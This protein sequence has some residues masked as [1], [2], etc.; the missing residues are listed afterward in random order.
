MQNPNGEIRELH[1]LV[2]RRQVTEDFV[3]SAAFASHPED[4]TFLERATLIGGRTVYRLRVRPP[5]GEPYVIGIDAATFLIDEK[6]YVD[7]DADNT[8]TYDD[9]RVVDGMLVPFLETDSNGNHRYDVVSHVRKVFVNDPIPS[10]IFKP[11]STLTVDNAQPVTVPIN[12]LGGLPFVHVVIAGETWQFLLDSGAQGIVFNSSVAQALNLRPRGT[13]EIRGAERVS[14]DGI[15]ETPDILIGGVT[16]PSHIATVL[17]LS[18]IVRDPIQFDGIIG[19]PL[20]AGAEVR[21]DPDTRT[22][23][24]AK[25]GTLPALG[26]K[27]DVDTDRELPEITASA[28]GTDTRFVVDTGNASEVL[29]YK[30]FIDAHPGL[31]PFAGRGFVSNRGIGGSAAAVGATLDNL[32]IGPYHLYNCD[33][34][35]MLATAGAFADRTDGGNIGYGLLRNFVLTFDLVHHAMYFEKAHIFDDGRYRSAQ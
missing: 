20:F 13:L 16:V 33:A 28:D 21:I 15:V 10:D 25:P 11:L 26:T 23:T 4:V 24:I 7:G 9:Y 34:N 22:M 1:G 32:G 12:I 27:L 19:S 14:A 8:T 5:N 29:L 30:G 31:V 17:D 18:K 35:V 6:S 3:D 2:A